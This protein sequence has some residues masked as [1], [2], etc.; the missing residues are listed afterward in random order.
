MSDLRMRNFYLSV[1]V[2]FISGCVAPSYDEDGG[3]AKLQ[4][5]R[6]DCLMLARGGQ[7]A[8]LR[9]SGGEVVASSGASCSNDMFLSCLAAKGWRRNYE[10]TGTAVAVG[11]SCND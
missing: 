10:G 4:Q 3:Y 7:K 5:D 9:A 6:M 8:S 1:L 11:I 2:I